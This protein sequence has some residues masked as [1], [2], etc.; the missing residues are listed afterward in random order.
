MTV[1]KEKINN[2][3]EKCENTVVTDGKISDLKGLCHSMLTSIFGG[4]MSIKDDY[5]FV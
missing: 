3:Y 5:Y 4:T 1:F 2:I